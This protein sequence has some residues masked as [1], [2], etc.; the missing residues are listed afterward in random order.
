M[1]GYLHLGYDIANGLDG[2]ELRHEMSPD[3]GHLIVWGPEAERAQLR[4]K[5]IAQVEEEGY[6]D[7]IEADFAQMSLQTVRDEVLD[8]ADQH[9]PAF[10]V[11]TNV[12]GEEE[13]SYALWLLRVARSRG[14]TIYVEYGG[15]PNAA[16]EAAVYAST[17]VLLGPDSKDA[18]YS[19]VG[20]YGAPNC[21]NEYVACT[22]TFFKP[23]SAVLT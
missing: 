11:L 9:T 18:A 8:R 1:T 10:V 4:A 16:R 22:S 2:E 23:V 17:V 7:L 20:L 12:S 15:A 21:T 13:S 3:G 19:V 6:Y 5:L 14:Q